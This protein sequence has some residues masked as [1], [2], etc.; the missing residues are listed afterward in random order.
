MPSDSRIFDKIE[1]DY[2]EN[3]KYKPFEA[4]NNSFAEYQPASSFY[5]ANNDSIHPEL[6]EFAVQGISLTSVSILGLFANSICLLVMSR[7]SLKKGQCSSV[8][9]L[10]TSMAAV[11]IIV[12]ICR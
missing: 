9:A 3:D 8:T 1:M 11:D 12:L 5:T 2:K 7:P 6:F 4:T 10:L